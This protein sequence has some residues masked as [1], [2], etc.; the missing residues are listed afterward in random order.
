MDA[1]V[2]LTP[3]EEAAVEDAAVICPRCDEPATGTPVATSLLGGATLV[4]CRRCGTRH[5]TGAPLLTLLDCADCGVPFLTDNDRPEEGSRCP[6]CAG[7][8]AP[9]YLPDALLAEATEREVRLALES[10]WRFVTSE[11]SSIYL[12]KVVRQ[13]ARRIDGAPSDCRVVL[14]EDE[15]LRTLALP[16]GTILVSEGAL[17]ELDDEAQLAFVLGHELAHVAS[18]ESAARMVRLGLQAVAD[19]TDTGA[20]DA[21]VDGAEDLIRLGFGRLREREADES[22]LQAMIELGYDPESALSYLRHIAE[23]GLRA[24]PRLDELALAH[25][26]APDRL[27]RMSEALRRRVETGDERRVNREVFR[28]V[29]GRHAGLVELAPLNEIASPHRSP[30][31]EGSGVFSWALLPWVGL[32]AALLV[33]LAI[34]LAFSL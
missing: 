11:P 6:D 14:F 29:A 15:A 18:G 33:A 13:L 23:L 3:P 24:D 32:A 1:S 31:D 16:S 28:R 21:W 30:R 26:P 12:T 4:R 34:L 8:T 27:R 17:A 19:E 25:P 9:A 5:T 2:T 10:H 7:E 20:E 22:S